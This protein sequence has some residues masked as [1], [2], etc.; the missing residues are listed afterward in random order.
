MKHPLD[1]WLEG[2]FGSNVEEDFEELT[3]SNFIVPEASEY[4]DFNQDTED[5]C[6]A[7]LWENIRKKKERMGKDYKPS[8]PGDSDR[9]SKDSFKKAQASEYQGRKVTLN[10][11]FRTPDAAKK[12]AVYVK[13][14]K[15]NIVKVNFGDPNL[16]IKKNIPSRKKSYCDR[17]RN[18]STPGDK[19][20]PNYW[21]RKQWSC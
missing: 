3:E 12:F 2:V 4:V 8:K 5:I 13:N 7:S 15:G 16:S 11:P 10:K 14:G 6:A 9:P 19:T 20:S 18:L 21:S 1:D 17:S